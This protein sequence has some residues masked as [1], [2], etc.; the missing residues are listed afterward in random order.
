[1]QAPTLRS[2]SVQLPSGLTSTA[3]ALRTASLSNP[4]DPLSLVSE[5]DSVSINGNWT[6]TTYAAATRRLVRT[7]PEGRQAF[8]TF[9]AKGRATTVQVAGFDSMR[10]S[11]DAPG[12]LRER[13]V[14]GRLWTYSY[15]AR[16]RLLST[17]D[18]LG[19]RDSLFYDDADQLIRRVLPNGRAVLFAYD[20]NGNLTSLSPSGRPAHGFQYTAVD[21]A[22]QYDPPG[23]PGPTPTRYF[24]NLD[25]QLDSIV[26]PDS[27]VIRFGYDAAGRAS[28]VTFDRGTLTFGYSPISGSLIAMRAPSGD[29]LTFS[30]D[31][32]LPTLVRWG[33][34]VQGSVGFSYNNDFRV[35]SQMVNGADAVSFGYD[36][37]GLLTSAGALRLG[38]SPT[39]GLLVA[40]TLGPV[41]STYQHNAHGELRGYR[42]TNGGS[43]LFGAGYARDSLGRIVQLFD[44]T[45][46]VPTRWSFEY[47]SVGRL[48]RDS[49]NGVVFHAFTYDPNG[50]RLSITSLN[51]TVNYSYDNQDRLL[52]AGTTS[53][54]YGSNGELKTKTVPGLGTTTYTYDA[55]G[56][57]VTVLLPAGT[58]IDYV[59]DGQNR[60]IGRKVNGVLVKGWLYQNQ[61]NPVAEVDGGGSVVSRFV[62]GSRANVPDYMIK[63]GVT[64]RLIADHLGS[65][66]LVVDTATGAVAQRLDYDEWG[67]ISQNTNPGFQPFGF[68]GGLS[69]DETA[70]VRFGARDYDPAVGRWTAS[71][72]IG[73]AGG[74]ANLYSYVDSDPV[75]RSDPSGLD[76][77]ITWHSVLLGQN[78]A[79]IWWQPGGT[80]DPTTPHVTFGAGFGQCATDG[81]CLNA[82]FNR[83]TDQSNPKG[84]WMKLALPCGVTELEMLERLANLQS[85]FME[86]WNYRL[87]YA[88][89][90][91]MPLSYNSNS[92]ARGLANAAGFST[93]ASV[94]H[95]PGWGHPVERRFFGP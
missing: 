78:H 21:L 92:F 61:L 44:T 33:G 47:D 63:S 83:P 46:G 69:D 80:P 55:L 30:S 71:D 37:D 13:Q 18:P 8:A 54:T 91:V 81:F 75:S 32:S 42:V 52:A 57:L 72:P 76:F 4:S 39:N 77:W 27:I 79:L 60:R 65:V 31:G 11:Y 23:I 64:Y 67:S 85:F 9:D 3:T 68:A 5:A 19:H 74:S 48:A 70:L 88:V 17:L 66:R 45:Q 26:R 87:R 28:S 35:F 94:P 95:A 1:M 15:D 43:T 6:V 34:A 86:N 40:D 49:V 51:G 10:L 16:D 84:G 53:Y 59:I 50:N 93:P 62:Y 25:R 58:R 56:N 20:G 14:G 12:R 24:Y 22:Q 2:L 90:P 73:F 89:L 41:R 29:S 82:E 36:R 7:S 38:R